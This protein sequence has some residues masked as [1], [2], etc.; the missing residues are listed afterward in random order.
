MT[1][2]NANSPA[3]VAAV[4]RIVSGGQTGVDRAALDAGLAAGIAIG[5]WCPRGRRSEAGTIPPHYPL[6]ETNARSYAV[7]TAWNVRDS[8]GTLIIVLDEISS[9]TKLTLAAARE[10]DKP[11]IVVH[12]RPSAAP[13]LFTTE[14]PPNDRI[15]SV[16]DWLRERR[17]R[18]LNVAGPRGSSHTDVYSE[19]LEF[20]T[21]LLRNPEQNTSA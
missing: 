13:G 20:M 7:R 17:I 2:E 4:T 9:G 18:V 3:A 1:K 12:L 15:Q 16:V 10:Q 8:D 14:N 21:L 11:F 5:G 19:A 6:K